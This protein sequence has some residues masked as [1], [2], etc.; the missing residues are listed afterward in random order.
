MATTIAGSKD[1][2]IVLLSKGLTGVI[3]IT[4]ITSK[5]GSCTKDIG[6]TKTMR[7]RST[8]A[9]RSIMIRTTTN[10]VM[11]TNRGQVP[12]GRSL[13]ASLFLCQEWL[14]LPDESTAPAY[15]TY[16]RR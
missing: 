6:I 1:A 15:A 11:T 12:G 5:A 10:K 2:G 4:T 13:P 8:L 3:L 16:H 7:A 9:A 14:A